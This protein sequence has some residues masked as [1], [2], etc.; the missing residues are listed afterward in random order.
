VA[1]FEEP[2]HAGYA[3]ALKVLRQREIRA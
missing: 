2:R 3:L 1:G